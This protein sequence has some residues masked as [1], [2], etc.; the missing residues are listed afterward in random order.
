MSVP[1]AP[2]GPSWLPEERRAPGWLGATL[3]SATVLAAAAFAA[4]LAW[5]TA[6]TALDGAGSAVL[7]AAP[8]LVT[9][10]AGVAYARRGRGRVAVLAGALLLVLTVGAW[11]GARG[12]GT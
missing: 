11:L 7:L 10:L 12:L 2:G 4:A 6:R 3:R 1:D 5:P 9:I 8:F